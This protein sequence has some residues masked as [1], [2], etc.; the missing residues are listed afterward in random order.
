LSFVLLVFSI[1]LMAC[2]V[3]S[4]VAWQRC[5]GGDSCSADLAI[6]VLGLAP[7]ALLFSIMLLLIAARLSAGRAARIA[8]AL[9]VGVA[10]LPLIAFTMAD[11][12]RSAIAAALI[13]ALVLSLLTR[14]AERPDDQP[15]PFEEAITLVEQTR[16]VQIIRRAA[17]P[18]PRTTA[19]ATQTATIASHA[20]IRD[21]AAQLRRWAALLERAYLLQARTDALLSGYHTQS[22]SAVAP[23][24]LSRARGAPPA[25]ED[26]EATKR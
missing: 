6:S 13:V 20:A 2:G 5:G 18:V 22:A 25:G 10:V 24:I 3:A 11:F 23:R 17:E 15:A 19:V 4:I 14:A 12:T 7:A 1:S 9:A 16:A 26:A 21:D 8:L